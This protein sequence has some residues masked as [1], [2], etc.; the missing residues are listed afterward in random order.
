MAARASLLRMASF[1][2]CV[3]GSAALAQDDTRTDTEAA[4]FCA[5]FYT[6]QIDRSGAHAATN[7]SALAD[8]FISVAERL[9]GVE[10]T[11][12]KADIAQGAMVGAVF[13]DG[14]EAGYPDSVAYVQSGID[15]CTEFG[16]TQPETLELFK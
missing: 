1:A 11:A 10:M 9:S 7:A 16:K 13:L 8:G 14:A 3:L 2:L 6:A 4:F 5:S 15:T 12:L